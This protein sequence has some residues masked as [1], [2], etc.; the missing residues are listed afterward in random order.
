MKKYRVNV[1]SMDWYKV[2]VEADT[3]YE[4]RQL[5]QKIDPVFSTGRTWERTATDLEVIDKLEVDHAKI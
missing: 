1:C 3:E 2:E 4:A 5:A